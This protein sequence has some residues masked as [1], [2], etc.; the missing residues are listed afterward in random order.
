MTRQVQRLDGGEYE[1]P[2]PKYGSER[3]VFI[4]RHLVEMLAEHV[5]QHRPG[6][7]PCRWLFASASGGA[8][9]QNSLVY[10]WRQTCKAAKVEG[11]TLHDLRHYYASGLITAGCDVVTVQ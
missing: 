9:A 7:D 5:A 1:V 6:D 3:Q 4:P 8:L 11:L 10:L 2:S